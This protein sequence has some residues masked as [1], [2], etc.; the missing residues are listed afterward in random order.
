MKA[1]LEFDLNDPDDA[2]AH[3][4]CVKSLEMALV[5]WNLK[6]DLSRDIDKKVSEKS[7]D[8]FIELVCRLMERNGILIDE[9]IN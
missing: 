8:A 2:M 6:N 3:L 5:L 7:K 1:I 4:R 9:L